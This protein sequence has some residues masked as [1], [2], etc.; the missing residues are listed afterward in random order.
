MNTE[1]QIDL[2]N[3]LISK[4]EDLN[5][6]N[7]DR[8]AEIEKKLIKTKIKKASR[9][10]EIPSIIALPFIRNKF[11]AFFTAGLFVNNHFHFINS[12]FK[13]KTE[14]PKEPELDN[15]KKGKDAL[16]KSLNL[17]VENLYYLDYLEQEILTRYPELYIDNEYLYYIAE[18]RAKLNNSY[19][20]LMKKKERLSKTQSKAKKNIK[21]LK[22]TL[23][24]TQ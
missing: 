4:V 13:R 21:A 22:K 6:M 11:F 19:I 2:N 14:D 16:N 3:Q 12:I 24:K 9:C 8:V 7:K 5:N 20:R 1:N 10:L 15:L 18:L 23:K 17:T